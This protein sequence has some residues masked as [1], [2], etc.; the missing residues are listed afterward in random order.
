M[1]ILIKAQS[2]KFWQLRDLLNKELP[3]ESIKYLI[4]N[5]DQKCSVTGRDNVFYLF[6]HKFKKLFL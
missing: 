6:W 2:E 1:N 3:N 5:N 4:E